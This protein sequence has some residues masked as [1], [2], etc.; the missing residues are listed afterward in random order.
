MDPDEVRNLAQ[1]AAHHEVL[2]GLRAA[3]R[4]QLIETRDLGFL[5]EGERRRLAG[6][7]SPATVGADEARYPLPRV[8][9]MADLASLGGADA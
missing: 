6:G 7:G 5:P 3:L 9:A 1:S 4:T 2:R 8:L